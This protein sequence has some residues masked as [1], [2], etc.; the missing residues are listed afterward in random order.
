MR[1]RKPIQDINRFHREMADIKNATLRADNLNLKNNQ[2][3]ITISVLKCFNLQTKSSDVTKIAPYFTYQFFTYEEKYSLT[4]RGCNPVYH[5]S[6]SYTL[7]LDDDTINYLNTTDLQIVFIDDEAP[8]S[9]IARGGQAAG[10]GVDDLIGIARIPLGDI[11][12]GVGI[13]GEF[14]IRGP[15]GDSRG[16]AQIKITIVSAQV[17][18]SQNLSKDMQETQKMAYTA[19]WEKDIIQRIAQ[20]LSKLSIDVELM[21]GIFSRGMKTCTHED[22]KYCC[23]QR[24]NMRNDIS[25]KELDLFLAGNSRL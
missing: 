22:F 25:E 16:K 20:K 21:F 14:E 13:D 5:D 6:Q 1:L 4:T 9:G 19:Q 11:P 2:K 7:T 24:L 8:M 18:Q 23:L 12:K 17:D 3:I 15:D 10:D